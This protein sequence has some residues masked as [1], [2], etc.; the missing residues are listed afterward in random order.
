MSVL[1]CLQRNHCHARFCGQAFLLQSSPL[2][3]RRAH[4]RSHS[5]AGPRRGRSR[6]RAASSL[7]HAAQCGHSGRSS[8]PS[9]GP[10]RRLREPLTYAAKMWHH[11]LPGAANYPILLRLQQACR[12]TLG[13]AAD[14]L[15]PASS[16][17]IKFVLVVVQ[18]ECHEMVQWV[19]KHGAPLTATLAASLLSST[20]R[21]WIGPLTKAAMA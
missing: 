4:C 14:E 1:F 3:S 2:F 17:P 20:L 19:Q 8:R 15:A 21:P 11:D 16:M 7:R 10:Q 5:Q 12:N 6:G 18:A 9:P 13:H